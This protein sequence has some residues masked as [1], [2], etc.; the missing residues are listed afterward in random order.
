MA[1]NLYILMRTDMASMNAGKGM[2]QACH[3]ANDA[4]ACVK[5]FIAHITSE[6][7]KEF[8]SNRNNPIIAGFEAWEKSTEVET[9]GTTLV[10]DAFNEETILALDEEFSEV[11]LGNFSGVITDPT[12]PIRDGQITHYIS[13]VTCGWVFCDE[14]VWKGNALAQTLSLHP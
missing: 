6:E 10:F 3:A 2:A 13:I 5:N 8:N 11:D 4:V 1:Y 14:A 7:A 9:F 12:Y